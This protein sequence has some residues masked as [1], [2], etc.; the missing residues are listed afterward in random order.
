MAIHCA[1]AEHGVKEE[2]TL[3]KLK[4]NS[5]NVSGGLTNYSYK[6]LVLVLKSL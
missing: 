2:S 6:R 3:V 4:D 5:D 1:A